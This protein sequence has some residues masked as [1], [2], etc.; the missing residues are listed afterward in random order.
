MSAQSQFV[1]V[2]FV[3]LLVAGTPGILRADGNPRSNEE[4][5]IALSHEAASAFCSDLKVPD[6]ASITLKIENGEVNRFFVQPLTESFRQH[7]LSLYARSGASSVDVL[8]SVADVRVTYGETFSEGV[9]S[10]RKCR[11]VVDIAVQF[12]ATSNADGK[13]LSAET[14]KRTFS[15]TVYADE[16]SKLQDSSKRIA[17]G[18]LP[19]RSV[20][21]RFIEPLIIVGAAG[22]AV[23][24]FFTIRS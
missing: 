3:V 24:L 23:Y 8:A 20:L 22:I 17:S 15:D 19:D 18:P 9:F 12:T 5:M 1:G 10:A 4:I 16:I 2:A 13:I 7:F 6:T 14:E 11:R 21:E